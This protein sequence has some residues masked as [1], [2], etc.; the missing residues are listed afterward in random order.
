MRPIVLTHLEFAFASNHIAGTES[1]LGHIGSHRLLATMQVFFFSFFL[2]G[3][4]SIEGFQVLGPGK[5][6]FPS[7]AG[8]GR[9]GF[10]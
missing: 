10:F 9:D 4:F 2:I 1:F 7:M 8:R 3:T 6:E 5:L